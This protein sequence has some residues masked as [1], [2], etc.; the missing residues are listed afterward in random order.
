MKAISLW[1][2]W[3]SLWLTSAKR[4]E[5]RSWATAHRGWLLVHAAVRTRPRNP[6]L[7]IGL[8]AICT[9]EFEFDWRDTLPKGALLGAVYLTGC[10]K[11]KTSFMLDEVEEDDYQCGNWETGRYAWER[12]PVC[13]KLETPVPY[14]GQQQVFPVPDAVLPPD[15][16]ELLR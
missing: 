16:L 3:A 11:I 9:R 15:F 1:Q 7:P 14:K 8:D 12:R 2:P 10:I 6:D 13:H 5:T 4:H